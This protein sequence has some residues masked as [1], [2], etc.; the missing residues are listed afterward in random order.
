MILDVSGREIPEKRG[1]GVKPESFVQSAHLTSG[2]LPE[3]ANNEPKLKGR[4]VLVVSNAPSEIVPEKSAGKG[5][6]RKAH[7]GIPFGTNE[8][9]YSPPPLKVGIK[10]ATSQEKPPECQPMKVL[11]PRH[12]DPVFIP[13]AQE[14]IPKAVAGKTSLP[15][16]DKEVLKPRGVKHLTP[17]SGARYVD[18]HDISFS[19]KA[20]GS[21]QRPDNLDLF[22]RTMTYNEP[23]LVGGKARIQAVQNTVPFDNTLGG[24]YPEPPEVGVRTSKFTT[25]KLRVDPAP[26]QEKERHGKM[27]Q[28]REAPDRS[29][30]FVFGTPEPPAFRTKGSVQRPV[31]RVGEE[32]QPRGKAINRSATEIPNTRPW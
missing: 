13:Q 24:Q 15:I 4:K 21:A 16:G 6:C 11:G 26:V 27:I 7:E 31:G 29:R 17:S 1:K 28:T 32:F 3:T 12:V 8:Q 5:A 14:K 18:D 9:V 22:T 23:V 30:D 19:K 20:K 25:H 10:R 2:M